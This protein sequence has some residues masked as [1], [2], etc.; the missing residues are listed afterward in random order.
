MLAPLSVR[1]AW[2]G[3]VMP[4]GVGFALTMW[5]YGRCYAARL[6]LDEMRQHFHVYTL[7]FFGTTR[8]VYDVS[9]AVGTRQH[10]GTFTTSWLVGDAPWRTIQ[11]TGRRLSLILDAQGAVCH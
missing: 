10:C 6:E 9:D 11:A 7:R 3:G 4:L 8:H 1:L 5:L 2:G